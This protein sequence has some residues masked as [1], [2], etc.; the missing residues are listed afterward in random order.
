MSWV[1]PD[2]DFE[3]L[4]TKRDSNATSFQSGTNFIAG[5]SGFT[6]MLP[7]IAKSYKFY[8]IICIYLFVL[9]SSI[10]LNIVFFIALLLSSKQFRER[11]FVKI[12]WHVILANLIICLSN[13]FITVPLTLLE[14]TQLELN[15][16]QRSWFYTA[17]KVLGMFAV[18]LNLVLTLIVA[19]QRL[20]V[21]VSR[22]LTI[23]LFEGFIFY[24]IMAS[25]WVV[26]FFIVYSLS[27]YGCRYMWHGEMLMFV[28]RCG[29]KENN[30]PQV[31]VTVEILV[32]AQN[33]SIPAI[34]FFIYLII[35]YHIHSQRRVSPVDSAISYEIE[36]LRQAFLIF[37]FFEIAS[38]FSMII[39]NKRISVETAFVF[40]RVDMT[41]NLLAGALTPTMFMATSTEFKDHLKLF[42]LLKP[43]VGIK[44]VSSFGPPRGGPSSS[45]ATPFRYTRNNN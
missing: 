10:V 22:R 13:L 20:L 21:F 38:F 17:F 29:D 3:D 37:V 5:L 39:P 6:D 4:L 23:L 9:F 16:F 33:I 42:A 19:I 31:T 26:T 27:Y 24:V 36:I 30:Y 7:N 40:N 18:E 8:I 43:K 34:I 15:S 41:L 25:A 12:L 28:F 44:I 11:A 2:F 14:Y 35:F 45:A 1:D 32:V